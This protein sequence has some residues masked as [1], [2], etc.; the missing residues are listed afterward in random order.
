[1]KAFVPRSFGSPD[2]LD[3]VDKARSALPLGADA[4]PPRD[5]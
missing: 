2:V 5:R 1:M 4:A 3:L